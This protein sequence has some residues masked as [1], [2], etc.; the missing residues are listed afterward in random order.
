MVYFDSI[1]GKLILN[2]DGKSIILMR[3]RVQQ[4]VKMQYTCMQMVFT[5]RFYKIK[6]KSGLHSCITTNNEVDAYI[7]WLQIREDIKQPKF[8][9]KCNNR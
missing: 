5:G 6:S 2:L 7:A 4:K 9:N 1:R 8:G 3:F